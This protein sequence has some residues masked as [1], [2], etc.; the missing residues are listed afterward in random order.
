MVGLGST[1][2]QCVE[3]VEVDPVELFVGG[4]PL[5]AEHLRD[6]LS[7]AR[8]R[9]GDIDVKPEGITQCDDGALLPTCASFRSTR[10]RKDPRY[11][12]RDRG[13]GQ[14]EHRIGWRGA[15][16]LNVVPALI[17]AGMREL[18]RCDEYLERGEGKKAADRDLA[19]LATV[20]VTAAL[21][22]S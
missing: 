7:H 19:Q 20:F 22:A 6:L 10:Q 5:D 13:G 18:S 3:A 11:G 15:H 17:T 21:L 9:A 16:S 2:K 4:S 14:E 12:L 1:F 8:I